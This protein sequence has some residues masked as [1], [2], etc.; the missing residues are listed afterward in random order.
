[1]AEELNWKFNLAD[2]INGPAAQMAGAIDLLSK[3]LQSAALAVDA[4]EKKMNGGGGGGGGIVQGLKVSGEEARKATGL[5]GGL[6]ESLGGVG[7]AI[8]G[9]KDIAAPFIDLGTFAFETA[10]DFGKKGV[11]A[12]QFKEN[13]LASFQ[14]LLGSAKEAQEFF[15][16]AA[17]LGKATPFQTKDVVEQYQRLLSAGFTKQEVPVVFQALGDAAA[18]RGFDPQVMNHIGN[19]LG[20][21]MSNGFNAGTERML[22]L[23]AAGTGFS[24]ER[25]KNQLAKNL[26]VDPESVQ[27]MMEAGQVSARQGVKAFIDVMAATAGGGITGGGMKAQQDTFSGILSTI[28]STY[29]DFFL[30]LDETPDKLKGWSTLKGAMMNL[31]DALDTTKDA[32]KRMQGA[33]VE[34][35][36]GIATAIFGPLSGPDGLK[37]M[38]TVIL[39][40]SNAIQLVGAIGQG[41]FEGLWAGGKA[42]LTTLGLLDSKTTSL[43]E[44]PMTPEKMEGIKK[45]MVDFGTRAG[46]AMGLFVTDLEKVFGVLD[47]IF[48]LVDRMGGL[49]QSK[50]AGVAAQVLGEFIPGFGTMAKLAGVGQGGADMA[51]Q[52]GGSTGPSATAVAMMPPITLNFDARGVKDPA[53]MSS[54]AENGTRKA[55][56]EYVTSVRKVA[57]QAGVQ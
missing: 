22:A 13:A 9:I 44:G 24:K 31:R 28:S 26:G 48:G 12:L 50:G 11:E 47:R 53:A 38:E 54:A 41:A 7:L 46:V 27:G 19:A 42:F 15:S 4:F 1:M 6:I 40:V 32:G 25:M 16:Q 34:A 10:W 52:P 21:I 29:Q 20:H 51:K 30:T 49:F 45:A 43:F 55:I 39:R 36:S 33:V 3:K 18:M 8:T 35:F 14:V 5:F 17:W 2:G 57:T 23:D 56:Q 37:N